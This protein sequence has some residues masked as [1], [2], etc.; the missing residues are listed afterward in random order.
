MEV[1]RRSRSLGLR[2]IW[3]YLVA[4]VLFVVAAIGIVQAVLSVSESIQTVDHSARTIAAANDMQ[5]TVRDIESGQRG[6]LLT[7][8]ATYLRAYER[9]LGRLDVRM[10]RLGGLLS[11]DPARQAQMD[12]IR[13]LVAEKLR[14]TQSTVELK[15]QGK[16]VQALEVVRSGAGEQAMEA[17]ETEIQALRNRE[18][19]L[20][21]RARQNA[22]AKGRGAIR[23]VLLAAVAI[24]LSGAAA[25][26]GM[27]R[28]RARMDEETAAGDRRFQTTFDE[29]GPCRNW[30]DWLTDA[31]RTVPRERRPIEERCSVARCPFRGPLPR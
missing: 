15:R 26:F 16:A 24:L 23:I 8:D 31:R 18:L 27:L 25:A 21:E 2:H 22:G 17:V 29:A 28:S 5:T 3:P 7:G 19:Q 20:N 9:S 1:M 12:R 11:A 6:Y 4:V 14:V 30:P 13:G 10:E